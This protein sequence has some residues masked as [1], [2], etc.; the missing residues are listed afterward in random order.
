MSAVRTP[1]R[2]ILVALAVVAVAIGALSVAGSLSSER[3][4]RDV[5]AGGVRV[6]EVHASFGPV[7]VVGDPAAED[8]RVHASERWWLVRP[9]FTA[10]RAGDRL[11]VRSTCR[12]SI[13]RGCS[14]R[15]A[16]VVPPGTT[17]EVATDDE[18]VRLAGLAGAVRVR[19]GDG[20]ITASDLRGADVDLVAGDAPVDV[21]FATA[22]PRVRVAAED[23]AVD[24]RVPRDGAGWRVEGRTADAPRE[25]EIVVDPAATRVIRADTLDAPV[26]IAYGG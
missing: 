7:D 2:A 22:P 14:G 26:R 8:V 25:V 18:P 4:T 19:S 3:A 9:S 15:I 5:T 13:G 23:G 6:V 24:V 10:T 17:V 16:V 1:V 21:A 11:V 20:A 12:V